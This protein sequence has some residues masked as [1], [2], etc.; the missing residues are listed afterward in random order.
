MRNKL[1]PYMGGKHYMLKTLL[2]LIPPHKQYV[3]VFGGGASLLFA[4][5]P[6][7][8][9]VYNDLNSDVYNFF[10]VARE[11]TEELQA[12]LILTPYSR[13]EYYFCARNLGCEDDIERARRF[14][15]AICQ[16]FGAGFN[17]IW[18]HV[19]KRSSPRY[20]TFANKVDR[21]LEAVERLRHVQIENLDFE[22]CLKTY[23]LPDTF[24]YCDPP[25]MNTLAD[26]HYIQMMSLEDQERFLKEVTNLEGQVIIS[27][28]Q[29]D[30]YDHYLSAWGVI[31]VERR[32]S[33]NNNNSKR[34]KNQEEMIW[35]SPNFKRQGGSLFEGS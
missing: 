11:H 30:L 34:V 35:L 33:I 10:R 14:F 2:P 9:E 7:A 15:V 1:L 4:K 26:K 21:L 31:K 29:S 27:G 19:K 13:E 32:C 25:Y 20:N 17:R 18:S 22:K 12:K 28:F 24:F 23:D 8:L 16:A 3:E 6:S 5:G